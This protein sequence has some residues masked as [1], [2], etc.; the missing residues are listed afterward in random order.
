MLAINRKWE[1][2][3]KKERKKEDTWWTK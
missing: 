3:E 2:L 1:E